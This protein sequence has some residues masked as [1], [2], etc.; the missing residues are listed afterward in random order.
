M[1]QQNNEPGMQQQ[2]STGLDPNLAG[3][4]CYLVH[5]I[6]GIV[7][8]VIEKE[9]RFIRFH[10]YQSVFVFGSFFISYIILSFIPFIGWALMFLLGILALVLWIFLMV[11]AYNG[12]YY[13]LPFFGDLAENQLNK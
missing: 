7:F 3:L 10:A 5:F 12:E 11:K 6:T 1:N 13:K 9:N 4:L 2:S 8:L